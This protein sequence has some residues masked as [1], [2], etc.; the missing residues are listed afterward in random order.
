MALHTMALTLVLFFAVPRFGQTTWRGPA[1][2]RNRWSA[3]RTRSRSASWGQIIEDPGQVM[4]VRFSDPATEQPPAHHRRDLLAGRNPDDLRR[5]RDIGRSTAG[6]PSWNRETELLE[7][8]RRR[9]RSPIWLCRTSPSRR[10]TT[11]SC[12]TWRLSCR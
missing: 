6:L 4:K 8:R 10:W 9:R 12:S 7:R 11:R 5:D 1:A 3:I 2:N